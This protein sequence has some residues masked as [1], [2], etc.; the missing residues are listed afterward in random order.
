MDLPLAMLRLRAALGIKIHHFVVHFLC[1]GELFSTI[2][3]AYKAACLSEPR[4]RTLPTTI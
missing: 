4:P 1:G 3:A 2:R